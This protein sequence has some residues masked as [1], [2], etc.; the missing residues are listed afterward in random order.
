MGSRVCAVVAALLMAIFGMPSEPHW[1]WFRF[2]SVLMERM[3][4]CRSAILRSSVSGLCIDCRGRGW[5][6]LEN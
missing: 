4:S 5:G 6:F 1:V 3:E 2:S